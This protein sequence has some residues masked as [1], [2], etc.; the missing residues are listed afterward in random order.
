MEGFFRAWRVAYSEAESLRSS[1]P[2]QSERKMGTN[3]PNLHWSIN[4]WSATESESAGRGGSN[5]E[6][7]RVRKGGVKHR[8]DI[9]KIKRAE[10]R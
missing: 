10:I 5:K 4:W 1:V 9:Q 6:R 8:L 2:T 3:S 7:D